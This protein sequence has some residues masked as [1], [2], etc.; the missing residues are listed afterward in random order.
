MTDKMVEITI[1]V[2]DILAIATKDIDVRRRSKSIPRLTTLEADLWFRKIF[3]ASSGT[4]R[5]GG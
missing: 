3:E 5:S 4:D 2:L 1:G